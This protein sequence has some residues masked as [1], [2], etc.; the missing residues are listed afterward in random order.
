MI[1]LFLI[2]IGGGLGSLARYGLNGFISEHQTKHFPLPALFPVGT[3]IVNVTGCFVIGVIAALSDPPLGR[4]GIKPEWRDFM[5]VGICGGYTTFSSFG[6]Q[7][8]NLAHDGEWLWAGANV[9]GSNAL[10]LLGVYLGWV[11][12][13]FIQ[14]KLHGGTL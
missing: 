4:G 12:G 6:L 10:C 8:L 14:A 3:M 13:R 1:K 11:C 9:I 5:M 7:T 2:A